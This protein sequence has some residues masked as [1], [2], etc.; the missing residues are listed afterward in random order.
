MTETI[1]TGACPA[2]KQG[3]ACKLRVTLKLG[4]EAITAADLP[5]LHC[6]EFCLDGIRKLYPDAVTFADGAFLVPLTQPETFALEPDTTIELDVR[7]HFLSGDVLGTK[8]RPKL[9]VVDA[10]SEVIL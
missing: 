9:A 4:D 5:L 2:I 8:Q 3:D 6:V 7:A 10:L 1:C